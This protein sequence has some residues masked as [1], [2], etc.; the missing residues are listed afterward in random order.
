M[1]DQFIQVPPQSTGLKVDCTEL[2]VGANLVERERINIADPTSAT[3]IAGVTVNGALKVDASATTQPISGT[4]T[5]NQG[6]ANATPWNE[7]LAQVGGSAV[8]LGAKT[9]SS[10]IPVVLAT[11]EA[12]LTVIQPTAANLNATVTQ[13]AGKVFTYRVF[14]NAVTALNNG[15]LP[16]ITLFGSATKLVKVTRIRFDTTLANSQVA[17]SYQLVKVSS[18]FTGGTSGANVITPMDSANPGATATSV[19]YTATPT[20]G[21]TNVGNIEYA[22]IVPTNL[23]GPAVSMQSIYAATY[24]GDGNGAQPIVLR[25]T[26]EG[27]SLQFGGT[28]SIRGFIEFTE[29]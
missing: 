5:S 26:S 9:S 13:V 21:G 23:T 2:T 27:I 20:G 24:G 18:A 14:L 16:T 8:S 28:P 17:N 10:S 12:A 4:I 6:A 19:T 15:A 3:A 1:A 7:N 25:G 29:E 11:D 22:V